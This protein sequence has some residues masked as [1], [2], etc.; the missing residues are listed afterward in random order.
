[1]TKK[2]FIALHS[3]KSGRCRFFLRKHNKKTGRKHLFLS[4]QKNTENILFTKGVQY[5]KDQCSGDA[6]ANPLQNYDNCSILK[7]TKQSSLIE[8]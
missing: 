8:K 5:V 1:M 2:R 7:S 4:M 6:F 3:Q